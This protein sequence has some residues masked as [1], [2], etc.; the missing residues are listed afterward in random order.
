L[1]VLAALL[2]EGA[3]T[4][5]RCFVPRRPAL[6]R[7]RS[8]AL[9]GALGAL[10]ALA[11]A[12]GDA[13]AQTYVPNPFE[14]ALI[15]PNSAQ[16][17][18]KPP[19]DTTR[20]TRSA[21]TPPIGNGAG[22]TG[23]DSTG[24]IAKKR[25]S[26]P[27]PGAPYPTPRAGAVVLRN[28]P[29][30]ATGAPQTAARATYANVYKPPD[31][32]LRRPLPPNTDPFEPVGVRVGSFLLRPSI[33]V[34]YGADSNPNRVPNGP[35]SNFTQ[36]LPEVQ[37]KSE[38]SRHELGATLRG[39]YFAYDDIPS[40]NRP[41]ADTKVVGRY[42]FNRDLRFD[43]EGRFLL[44]TDNPGSPNLQADLAKLPI[45]TT[46]G[47]T[48]GLAQRFNRLELA[49]KGNVDRT[50]YQDSE[51]TDGT[52][53]SN[54]DR[55]YI[56]YRIQGRVSYEFT[57]G[58]RP[59]VELDADKRIH[60]NEDTGR[61]SHALTPK[62]GMTFELLRYLTGELSV[63]YTSREYEDPTLQPLKGFVIDGSLAWVAT[64][65]TTVT[66]TASSRTAESPLAGVSGSLSRDVAISV[67]HAFR[68]WLIGTVKL[69]YGQDDYVGLDRLDKR[70]SLAA[71]VTYKFS[72]ELWLKGEFR[73][74]WMNSTA[75][76]VNYDAS[77]F[78][79][80]VKAQR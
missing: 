29:L 72:R 36:I 5:A 39:S 25:K 37:I 47:A 58:F 57:P 14:P 41:A 63:G 79:I 10:G 4:P 23:F 66:L 78:L 9:V 53:V 49:A 11:A 32:P 74:E 60:D 54:A 55:N 21:A 43:G 48:A 42:D 31:A 6:P 38:W 56:Q 70:T 73:Q 46:Y 30:Q 8:K 16:R 52:S 67:D 68:R 75:P 35:R 20:L 18:S 71:I 69:G 34:G 24:S 13:S 7:G 45:Y 3:R 22:E 80:G 28:L 65:L 27:K 40:L 51:L 44:G 62:V 12:L 26:K 50:T 64:G 2:Q 77:I 15:D 33:E 61:D 1:P 59:F 17:F 19:E 76:G